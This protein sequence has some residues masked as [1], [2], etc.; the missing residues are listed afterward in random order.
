[1]PA[2]AVAMRTPSM[3][4]RCGS[5]FGAKGEIVPNSVLSL[6]AS[7]YCWPSGVPWLL[8]S[9]GVRSRSAL[10]RGV[11]HRLLDLGIDHLDLGG[12]AQARDHFLRLRLH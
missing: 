5:R 10:N 8:V 11:V 1:M 7:L 3:A 4:G 12:V 2:A 6:P 9:T